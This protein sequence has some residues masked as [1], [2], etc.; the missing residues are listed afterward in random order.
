MKNYGQEAPDCRYLDD[1]YNA[2]DG[3]NCTGW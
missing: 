1:D 3:N 2:F